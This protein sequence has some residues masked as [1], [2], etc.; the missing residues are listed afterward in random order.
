MIELLRNSVGV[1][2][3]VGFSGT[4]WNDELRM[5]IDDYKIGGLVLFRRNIVDSQQ[6]SDLVSTIQSRALASLGRKLFIAVDQE[7]GAVRRLSFLENPAP[8]LLAK[9]G[10][11][12]EERQINVSKAS[13][14]T[15]QVLRLHGINVNLA[16]VLDRVQDE[17]TH[18]LGSR[19]FGN[20]PSEVGLLG[21]L[22]IQIH[23]K[24]GV[25]SVA[26]HFP[27]LSCALVDPHEHKLSVVWQSPSDMR[28]DLQPF[29]SAIRAGIFGVMVSHG[30]Y[31]LWDPQ[32]PAPLST[33]VCREWLRKRLSFGG[34]VLSD[35]LDMKAISDHFPPEI[36]AERSTIAGVDCLLVC[37]NFD[38][39]DKLY[40]SLCRLIES[41]PSVREAHYE[42]VCRIEQKFQRRLQ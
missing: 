37:N 28:A 7:G 34:L 15:A 40:G 9:N 23:K 16:P 11:T 36:V 33:T 2:F 24:H 29:E 3:W 17:T 19:S 30:I 14:E 1:R 10:D 20:D 32:W 22:W 12:L 31:P 41:N 13:T 8:R 18:F 25:Y 26:K 42:S 5:L 35:D 39:F 4:S 6:L 27:G 21:S 38:H